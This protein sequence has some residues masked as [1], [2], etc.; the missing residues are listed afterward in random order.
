MISRP[1]GAARW[2]GE[3]LPTA[4]ILPWIVICLGVSLIG[5]AKSGFGGGIGLV[6]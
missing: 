4:H 6:V 1:R 5:I 2:I 3:P